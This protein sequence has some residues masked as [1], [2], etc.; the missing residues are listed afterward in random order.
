MA[1]FP[2]SLLK[3]NYRLHPDAAVDVSPALGII[4]SGIPGPF[5]D[6][7]VLTVKLRT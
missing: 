4:S 3:A 5:A 2:I 7:P 1:A 6:Y